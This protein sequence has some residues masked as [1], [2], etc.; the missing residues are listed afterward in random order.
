[1]AAFNDGDGL[2][3]MLAAAA[4][5][6]VAEATIDDVQPALSAGV[7][8]VGD[9]LRAR[10]RH[11]LLRSAVRQSSSLAQRARIH[12]ALA[13][14]V[15]DPDRRVWHRAAATFGPD[16]ELAGQLSDLAGRALRRGA[17]AASMAAWE[18]AAQLTEPGPDRAT[19]LVSAARAASE[20]GDQPALLRLLRDAEEYDLQPT[21][22]TTAAW[23]R[24]VYGSVSW[25]GSSRLL[26]S[27]EIV[28]QAARDGDPSWRWTC[29]SR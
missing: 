5:A 1:M 28:E 25:T 19:R 8:E 27:I 13:G 15:A 3:E 16:E 21:H 10:F 6:G 26:A 2:D 7:L 20:A 24:E 12:A 9:N 14:T 11:P 23:L 4:M 17:A 29:W 22:R 18:R